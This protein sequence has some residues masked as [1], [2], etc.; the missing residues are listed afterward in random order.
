MQYECK[1][2]KD[3]INLESC[4][5]KMAGMA[6]TRLGNRHVHLL[7]WK[8]ELFNERYYLHTSYS[9]LGG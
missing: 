5:Y 7:L 3:G 4:I 2:I 9:F 8:R 1:L 6:D